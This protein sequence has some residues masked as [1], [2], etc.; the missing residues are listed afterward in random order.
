MKE[1]QLSLCDVVVCIVYCQDDIFGKLNFYKQAI[2][3]IGGSCELPTCSRLSV[4]L[5][6]HQFLFNS[7]LFD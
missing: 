2:N 3:E 5:L 6:E 7:T 1:P 4:P